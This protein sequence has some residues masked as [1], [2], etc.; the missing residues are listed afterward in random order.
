M[1]ACVS[2]L[3]HMHWSRMEWNLVQFHSNPLQ[4]M[5]IEMNTCA[6]KHG[7][8]CI[9]R[10]ITNINPPNFG[11]PPKFWWMATPD[12]VYVSVMQL[13][14]TWDSLPLKAFSQYPSFPL[15]CTI[16]VTVR[17]LRC[18]PPCTTSPLTPSK[19]PPTSSPHTPKPL[20]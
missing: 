19:N 2:S 8:M 17:P 13:R 6:S 7:L 5:W 15:L 1:D 16:S 9:N 10:R 11:G 4:H 20:A 14:G 12:R 18:H 3:I